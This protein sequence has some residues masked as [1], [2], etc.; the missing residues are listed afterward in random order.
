MYDPDVALIETKRLGLYIDSNTFNLLLNQNNRLAIAILNYYNPNYKGYDDEFSYLIKF[1]RDPLKT[2]HKI[3][4]SIPKYNIISDNSEIKYIEYFPFDKRSAAHAVGYKLKTIQNVA[5][6]I[7]K[8][9]TISEAE[10]KKI[11]S[12]FIYASLNRY[13]SYIF[14]TNEK[15][16]LD[17]RF[18]FKSHV[19]GEPLYIMSVEEAAQF[20]NLYLKKRSIYI[21]HSSQKSTIRFDKW[22]WYFLSMRLKLHH[23]N[24]GEGHI[25]SVVDRFIHILIALDEIGILSYSKIRNATRLDT[26]YHFNYLIPLITGIFDNIALTLD[27]KLEINWPYLR[28]I[29]LSNTAGEK[30]LKEIR[31]KSPVIRKHINSYV[32]FINLIYDIREQVI[33]RLGLKS[34]GIN[35]RDVD[36]KLKTHAI[37]IPEKSDQIVWNVK[38]CGDRPIKNSPF[39]EWGLYSS[40]SELYIIPYT[41]SLKVVKTLIEFIEK[42]LE[43]LGYPSFVE[44]QMKKRDDFTQNLKMFEQYH[45]GF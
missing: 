45:L 29:S 37:R 32:H 24:V 26:L 35:Y 7:Y 21:I 9:Q 5:E 14:I 36:L 33:H 6:V 42:F 34:T 8:K 11:I 10:L 30:Y 20:L 38:Q 1:I 18:W 39:S 22:F 43:L 16:L 4:K 19:P 31:R 27:K 40:T 28:E 23:Y 12:V 25:D 44:H 3:L 15:I 17:N 13:N 2:S 41:F